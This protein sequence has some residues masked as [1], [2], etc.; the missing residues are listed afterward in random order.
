MKIIALTIKLFLSSSSELASEEKKSQTLTT[1]KT[2]DQG[3]L[4]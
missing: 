2:A 3:L 4:D 1:K